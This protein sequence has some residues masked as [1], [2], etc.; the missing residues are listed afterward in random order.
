MSALP[1]F[2]GMSEVRGVLAADRRGQLSAPVSGAA[3]PK[4]EHAGPAAAALGE[5]TALGDMAGLGTLELVVTSA[6]TRVLMTA[7]RA[8]GFVVVAADPA[9][10]T[11]RIEKVLRSWAAV[12]AAPRQPGAPAAPQPEA[13]PVAAP[14]EPWA[15]LRRALVRGDLAEAGRRQRELAEAPAPA[16][17]TPGA[18]PLEAAERDRALAAL[19]DAIATV[20]AGD[21]VGAARRL[22]EL[23]RPAL[24]NLSLRWLAHHWFARAALQGGSADTARLHVKELL[25]L[26]KQLG[27]EAT[28]VSQW[29]A[30]E[31]LALSSDATQGLRWLGA[32]RAAFARLGDGWGAART[33]LAEARLQAA[34]G[35]EERCAAAARRAAEA[36]PAWEEPA[37]FLSRRALFRGDAARAEQLLPS[38]ATPAADRVRALIDAVRAGKVAQAEAS[39]LLR[40]QDGPP[41]TRTLHALHRIANASPRFLQAREALAWM[42]LKRGKYA[43][44]SVIFRA[45][46]SQEL[47]PAERAAVEAGLAC[48]GRALP[49]PLLPQG[50]NGAAPAGP[51][52]RPGTVFS[53]QLSVFALPDLLE[54]LRAGKRTGLLTCSSAAG[55]GA[56]RF[57]GGRITGAS[58]PAAPALGDLLLQARQVTPVTLRAAAPPGDEVTDDALGERLVRDGAV[59][60]AAVEGALRRRIELAL[61]Q[62]VGWN[63]GEFAF[64]ESAPAPA[65]G[66]GVELDA[67]GLLL[68][69]FKELDEAV[70][71]PDAHFA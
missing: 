7:V 57:R 12:A 28:A 37:L 61:R 1:L 23:T 60:V 67:Q 38:P 62:L 4:P 5:L 68:N 30:G 9:K 65:A 55:V 17:P 34:A 58:S 35:D 40:E 27:D 63:D 21:S 2:D 43:E 10:P 59:A 49:P 19:L 31:L 48:A 32:A 42:L 13:P 8:A 26:A 16:R 6:P 45:L 14:G 56:L 25:A 41:S 24:G 53:G 15:A 50:A 52:P 3:G 70:R 11:A 44:A 51:T 54:F 47:A 69:V 20:Q 22:Q 33:W 71:P 29:V 39:E 36:D 66:P 64:E 18:E 46:L